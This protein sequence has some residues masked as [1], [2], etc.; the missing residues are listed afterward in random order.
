[1]SNILKVVSRGALLRDHPQQLHSI[2]NSL[3]QYGVGK[4]VCRTIW[5]KWEEPCYYTITR[6]RKLGLNS[7]RAWGY[8]TFRGQTSEK[9]EE[10]RSSRKHQWYLVD[11]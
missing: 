10:I 5:S 9:P 8:L 7:V 3:Y 2:C 1:M 4:K 11:E 6:V